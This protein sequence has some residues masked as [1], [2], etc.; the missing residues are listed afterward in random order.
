M[1]TTDAS[2]LPTAL[3]ILGALKTEPTPMPAAVGYVDG[4]DLP[5]TDPDFTDHIRTLT[6]DTK[7]ARTTPAPTH[8]E[9]RPKKAGLGISAAR[10]HVL[11]ETLPRG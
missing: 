9:R 10:R 4:I 8:L 11:R 2:L 3:R 1:T 7:P 6:A 5:L